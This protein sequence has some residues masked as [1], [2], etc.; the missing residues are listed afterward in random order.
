MYSQARRRPHLRRPRHMLV[1]WV[2]IRGALDRCNTPCNTPGRRNTNQG[3]GATLGFDCF[4]RLPVVQPGGAG[5]TGSLFQGCGKGGTSMT[6]TR[7]SRNIL[8]ASFTAPIWSSAGGQ[9]ARLL[10]AGLHETGRGDLFP[11]MPLPL[12]RGRISGGATLS[13]DPQERGSKSGPN[14]PGQVS[15]FGPIGPQSNF[16]G[17]GHPPVRPP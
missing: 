17:A 13:G 15:D 3:E 12:H 8:W 4:W 7:C 6:P 14:D 9:N 16:P 10:L 2:R 1:R 11:T 5:I